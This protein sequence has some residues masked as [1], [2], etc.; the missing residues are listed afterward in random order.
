MD[1]RTGALTLSHDDMKS[2]M[3]AMEMMF[4][5]RAPDAGAA[6][7]HLRHHRV[8]PDGDKVSRMAVVSAKFEAG[9]VFL[10]E[11]ASWLADFEAE[12]FAFPG[13]RNDDQC[14]S[15][16]QALSEQ[17]VRFPLNISPETVA[18]WAQWRPRTRIQYFAW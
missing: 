14:D 5:V 4:R 18:R 9:Q 11:R 13:S 10:P 16:S 3:C 6:Y 1:K 2:F 12:L 8:R 7:E 15:V 17:N